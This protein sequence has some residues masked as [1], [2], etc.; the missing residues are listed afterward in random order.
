[1]KSENFKEEICERI[2]LNLLKLAMLDPEKLN[3]K[4]FVEL[5]EDL[6]KLNKIKNS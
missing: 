3:I 4:I 2:R 6:E 5:K 1:M